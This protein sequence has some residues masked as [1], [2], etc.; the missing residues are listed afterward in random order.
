VGPA[1]RDVVYLAVV[2]AVFAIVWFALRGVE[3]L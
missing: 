2:I 1:M 3:K